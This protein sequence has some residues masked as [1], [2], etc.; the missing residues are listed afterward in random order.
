MP[1]KETIAEIKNT[2][3]KHRLGFEEIGRRLKESFRKVKKNVDRID[4]NADILDKKINIRKNR[5]LFIANFLA[6]KYPEFK[7]MWEENEKKWKEKR[8]EETA[9][10][11]L[12]GIGKIVKISKF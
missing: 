6:D 3:T 2:L 5:E 12:V 10:E 7:G 8:S 9:A 11:A 1:I 4:R